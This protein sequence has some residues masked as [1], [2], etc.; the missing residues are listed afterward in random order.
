[1]FQGRLT[2]A[3][4]LFAALVVVD[5]VYRSLRA[6][7][8]L[9][10]MLSVLRARWLGP[11][12]AV[13]LSGLLAYHLIYICYRNLKSWDAFNTVRD[14]QLLDF[15]IWL[16]FGS[17]PASLLHDALGEGWAAHALAFVY[18]SFTYL[19][20]LSVVAALVFLDRIRDGYV[21]LTAA[22]WTW[23]LG[24]GSYYLVP[25]LG[26]FASAPQDFVDLPRTKITGTQIEYLSQRAHL[27]ANR[28]DPDAFA[29]ISAFASL[30]TGFTCMVLMMLLY[31]GRTRLAALLAV[32]LALTMLA[33]IYFG[34]H[35]VV[36]DVA[37]V[38]LAY[39]AVLFARLMIYPRAPFPWRLVG[40]AAR[41]RA[42][43]SGGARGGP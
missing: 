34:W 42:W 31:Y 32:Y 36:D 18:R 22:M 37:G 17:S 33:T 20:P 41:D 3:L 1:M 8:G 13:V 7:G 5:V 21:L 43:A 30:H 27:L 6:G 12:L 11:R 10:G 29:S 4:T 24:L 9:R 25:S 14:Q 28:D 26:P 16:F 23:V 40:G 38:L 39:L 2:T 15:E 35:F 19:V